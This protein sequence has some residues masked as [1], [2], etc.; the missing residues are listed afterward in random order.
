MSSKIAARLLESRMWRIRNNMDIRVIRDIEDRVLLTIRLKTNKLSESDFYSSTARLSE[1]ECRH[2]VGVLHFNLPDCKSKTVRLPGCQTIGL[3]DYD[4]QSIRV[5]ESDYYTVK[6]PDS[7]YQT[8]RIRML[9]CQNQTMR[10]QDCLI[11][12]IRLQ[13]QDC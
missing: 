7:D 6:L 9:D 12:T 8:A 11:Q 1:S 5:P 10:I 4:F 2:Y 13:V 3:S